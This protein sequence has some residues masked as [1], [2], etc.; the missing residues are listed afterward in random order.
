MNKQ[1]FMQELEYR[2]RHLTDD[3]RLDALEYYSEYIDDLN[4]PPEGDVCVHLGTPKEVARQIIAQTT[5]RK[6]EEQQEKKTTKGF[7]SIVWLAIAAVII[8]LAFIIVIGSVV[9][10]FGVAGVACI[11]AGIATFVIGL[12]SPGFA[13]KLIVMGSGLFICGLGIMFML[14]TSLLAKLMVKMIS[15]IIR[16]MAR[17]HAMK[18]MNQ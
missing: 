5:E 17:R 7:G 6:I 8:F 15:G 10:S 3:D 18:K 13:Q 2:L 9:F 12:V 14:L 16:K 1:A 11:A 4:L